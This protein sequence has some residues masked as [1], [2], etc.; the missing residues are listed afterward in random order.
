MVLLMAGGAIVP[1]RHRAQ[2][3][4]K[5]N[6]VEGILAALNKRLFGHA[7]IQRLQSLLC[8]QSPEPC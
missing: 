8:Q 4:H 3:F 5:P 1:V 2:A 7:Q 6:A